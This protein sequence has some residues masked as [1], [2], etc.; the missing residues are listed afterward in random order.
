[1]DD[2]L[3]KARETIKEAD[4]KIA[5][6]F[7]ERMHAVKEVAAYKKEHGLPIYDAVQEEK[8]IK[9]SSER[10]HDTDL[11]RYYV[12]LVENMMEVSKKYQYSLNKGIRVAYNGTQGAY[13]QIAADRIFKK[14]V[15][16]PCSSFSE[17]YDCV[18][19][20]DCD[21][22]VLPIENSYAGEVGTVMD[23]MFCG[24][25]HVTGVYS[26][27]IRHSLL[28]ATDNISDIKTVVSH[29]QALTQCEKYIHGRGWNT[30]AV[31]STADA[32]KMVSEN[33]DKS[34]AA[35]ASGET[36]DLFG[37]NVLDH[38]I[39]GSS[40]NTTKFAVFSKADIEISG[41]KDSNFILMF[42]ANDTAGS[43]SKAIS[44]I[45]HYGFNMKVLRSRSFKENAWEYYFYTEVEG[46]ECSEEGR[47]MLDA[48]E[49]QCDTI[50]VIGHYKSEI[51]LDEGDSE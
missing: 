41:K 19:K 6:L 28:G 27:P 43:L 12:E 16:I 40:D 24:K 46:D 3:T 13:A 17:A 34:L 21:C 20:G 25:L 39:N 50:K 38:D 44:V 51:S 45:S 9:E 14:A 18:L 1:M 26:L 49:K 2:R 15:T 42:T 30:M 11:K 48:L 23:I 5:K 32:A 37:L 10:I 4:S 7:E 33:K 22:A 36:S 35:I 47:K 29:P 31:S 8:V